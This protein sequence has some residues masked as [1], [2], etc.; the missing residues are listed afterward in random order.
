MAHKLAANDTLAALTLGTTATRLDLQSSSSLTLQ[1]SADIWYAFEGTD[2]VALALAKRV[3]A[4]GGGGTY[5]VPMPALGGAYT[6]FVQGKAGGET[7]E[8]ITVTGRA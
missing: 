4:F 8:G 7:V 1:A 2:G 3:T 6:V 5:N